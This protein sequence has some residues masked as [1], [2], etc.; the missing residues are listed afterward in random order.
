M[1]NIVSN[2]DNIIKAW[3]FS[4]LDMACGDMIIKALWIFNTKLDAEKMAGTLSLLL[5][6][7]PFLAGRLKSTEGISC[8]N[9]GFPFEVVERQDIEIKNVLKS[10]HIYD[11]FSLKLN[12]NDFKKGKCAP[13]AICVTNLNDGTVLS[14]QI[15]HIC[16][17]GHSFYKM[18]NEWGR[19]CRS[20][21]VDIQQNTQFE[22]PKSEFK[23]KAQVI[24]LLEK[25]SWTKLGF[26][27]IF[28]MMIYGASKSSKAT[29]TPILI[30]GEKIE[31][32]RS[33]A[34]KKTGVKIGTNAILS[35]VILKINMCLNAFNAEK[36]Y[37][38][39]TVTDLRGRCK[40]ISDCYI[41]NASSNIV[42]NSLKDSCDV[43][44]LALHIQKNL[45]KYIE[46]HNGIF[47]E[48]VDLSNDALK[49]RLPYVSFDISGMNAKKPTVIYVNDQRKLPVYELDF[50]LGKPVISIPND[51]PDMVKIW[52]VNDG[53]QSVLLFFRG[54]LAENI[55][56]NGCVDEILREITEA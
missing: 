18:M 5:E 43:Y 25:K 4:L 15:A 17:D 29:C 50:G 35:A 14:A 56:K 11:D 41:G 54:H 38:L 22:F 45:N 52:P 28:K 19:L 46:N 21:N 31:Q 2:K 34:F 44:E 16:M 26:K 7:Y 12:I 42:T 33:A 1:K 9:K 8:S 32:F 23:S 3:K 24:S 49:Y 40:N 47:D 53:K 48:H 27:D 39:V 37:S 55:V 20:E 6:K 36:D 51:L 13:I 30:N 10:K